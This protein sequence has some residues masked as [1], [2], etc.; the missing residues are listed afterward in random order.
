MTDEL[1]GVV[2]KKKVG[3][4]AAVAGDVGSPLRGEGEKRSTCDWGGRGVVS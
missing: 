3:S 4:K 1:V 2:Q